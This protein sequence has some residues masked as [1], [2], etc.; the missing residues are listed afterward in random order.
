MN[1]PNVSREGKLSQRPW[2]TTKQLE[3]TK[4]PSNKIIIIGR[5][6]S[7]SPYFLQVREHLI[8]NLSRRRPLSK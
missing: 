5:G 1:Q 2:T 4:V 7:P 6:H 3:S 8:I